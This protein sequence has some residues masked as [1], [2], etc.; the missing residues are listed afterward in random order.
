VRAGAAGVC[1]AGAGVCVGCAAFVRAGAARR[2]VGAGLVF[3][4][5]AAAA[6]AS[7]KTKAVL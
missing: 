6:A 3:E 4:F 2:P 1:P 5:C 7:A